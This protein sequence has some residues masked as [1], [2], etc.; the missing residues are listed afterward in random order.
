MQYHEVCITTE[1][2]KTFPILALLGRESNTKCFL[3][4]AV[5]HNYILIINFSVI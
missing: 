5:E 2:S 1:I 3:F 4:F